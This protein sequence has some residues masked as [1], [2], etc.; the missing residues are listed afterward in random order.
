M[1]PNVARS[2]RLQKILYSFVYI[3]IYIFILMYIYIHIHGEVL[4]ILFIELVYIHSISRFHEVLSR[5]CLQKAKTFTYFD[6]FPRALFVYLDSL[7]TN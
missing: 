2:Q 4:R 1:F 7:C 6:I 3:F 5:N